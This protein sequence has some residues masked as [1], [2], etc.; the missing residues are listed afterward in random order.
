MPPRYPLPEDSSLSL[1]FHETMINFILSKSTLNIN[2]GIIDTPYLLA[3]T[4]KSTD[5]TATLYGCP[6]GVRGRGLV[7]GLARPIASST[8]EAIA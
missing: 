5:L 2:C 6:G 3:K 4:L 1:M 8:H 7:V